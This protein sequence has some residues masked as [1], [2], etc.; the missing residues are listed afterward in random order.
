MNREIIHKYLHKALSHVMEQCHHTPLKSGGC[1]AK[2][3]R[4]PPICK[5]TKWACESSLLLVFLSNSNLIIS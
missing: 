4:H 5:S 1:I 3:K 2:S